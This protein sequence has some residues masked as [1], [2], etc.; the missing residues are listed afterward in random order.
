MDRRLFPSSAKESQ[1][2]EP[3]TVLTVAL[4]QIAYRKFTMPQKLQNDITRCLGEGCEAKHQ[5]LRYLTIALDEEH[6]KEHGFRLRSCTLSLHEEEPYVD[7][8][9]MIPE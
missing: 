9:Y 7:C 1:R 2:Q 6:D 8:M 4:T 5:C 3:K